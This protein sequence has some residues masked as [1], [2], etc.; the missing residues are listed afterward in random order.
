MYALA[1]P[2]RI[3]AATAALALLSS[4]LAGCGGG[5][6]PSYSPRAAR[7]STSAPLTHAKKDPDFLAVPRCRFS[8]PCANIP[9]PAA[10]NMTFMASTFPNI[11]AISIG[12]LS[13]PGTVIV[14]DNVVRQGKIVD[15]D[16]S[17]EDVQ[18]TRR[19]FD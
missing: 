2:A 7:F 11:R 3:R 4:F 10:P 16:S 15:A 5:L 9:R 6:D 12:R 18:G 13:R 1:F 8:N 19:M 17:D 14:V